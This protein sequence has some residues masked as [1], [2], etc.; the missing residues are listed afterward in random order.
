MEMNLLLIILFARVTSN[1]VPSGGVNA[2]MSETE[3]LLTESQAEL[4]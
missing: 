1:I 3:K 4:K 2:A